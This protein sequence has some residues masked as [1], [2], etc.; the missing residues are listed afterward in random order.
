MMLISNV[1]WHVNV[2]NPNTTC[3]VLFMNNVHSFMINVHGPMN[4]VHGPTNSV[5]GLI[6]S[7]H[8]L[9]SVRLVIHS[10]RSY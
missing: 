7:V 1:V 10:I 9:L 6:N 3:L 5:H 2:S 8:D 4:N